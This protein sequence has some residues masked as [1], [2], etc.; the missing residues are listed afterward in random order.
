MPAIGGE[1]KKRGNQQQS[2]QHKLESGKKI[3]HKHGIWFRIKKANT[4]GIPGNCLPG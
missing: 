2:R 3:F 4:S 1:Q